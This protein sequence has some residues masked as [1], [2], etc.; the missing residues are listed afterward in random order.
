MELI[1]VAEEGDSPASETL[2]P[3]ST[4]LVFLINFIVSK[5]SGSSLENLEYG[6]R[7]LLC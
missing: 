3:N 7:D 4:E 2:F 5:S 6:H 1:S